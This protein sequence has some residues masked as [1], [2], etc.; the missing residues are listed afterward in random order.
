MELSGIKDIDNLIYENVRNVQEI[1]I[2]KINLQIKYMQ[3]DERKIFNYIDRIIYYNHPVVKI[4]NKYKILLTKNVNLI[5]PQ[6]CIKCGNYHHRGYAYAPAK[7]HCK[8]NNNEN[9]NN[10]NK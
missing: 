8:C 6:I 2:D 3:I 4:N 5:M 7:I 1:N 10:S 9:I